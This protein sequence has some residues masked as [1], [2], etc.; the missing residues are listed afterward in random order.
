M[1][2][3]CGSFAVTSRIAVEN[4]AGKLSKAW[5]KIQSGTHAYILCDSINRLSRCVL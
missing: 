1:E 3:M 2:E 4:M 5:L